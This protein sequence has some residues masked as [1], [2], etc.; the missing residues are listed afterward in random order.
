MPTVDL[1]SRYPELVWELRTSGAVVGRLE[2]LD[3]ETVW[4]S[5]IVILPDKRGHGYA[6][7]LLDA[8][9]AHFPDITIGLAANPL[10]SPKGG[11]DRGQLQAWYGRHGF[12]PAPMRGDPHRMIRLPS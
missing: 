12:A 5:S 7:L 3:G 8:V 6:S 9:L 2:A 11:L 1:V 4:I 10:P